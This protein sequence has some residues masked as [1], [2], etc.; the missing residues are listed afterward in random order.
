[1][2]DGITFGLCLLAAIW[3]ENLV[4]LAVLLVAALAA[5]GWPARPS[6]HY[7]RV[8]PYCGAHLDPGELCDCQKESRPSADDTEAAR[9]KRPCEGTYSSLILDHRAGGVK[10]GIV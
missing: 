7:Y 4:L 5:S 1:M 2:K 3:A 8:C 6:G 9:W 10:D